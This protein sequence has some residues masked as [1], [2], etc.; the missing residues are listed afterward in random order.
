MY[1]ADG[2][3]LTQT[4]YDE[5]MFALAHPD[6][7][8]DAVRQRTGADTSLAP[9]YRSLFGHGLVDCQIAH[10]DVVVYCE[11]TRK[12]SDWLASYEK[13]VRDARRATL[14]EVAFAVVN[15]LLG[16]AAG[17]AVAYLLF[18]WYGIA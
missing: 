2:I 11:P 14:K 5:L 8:S 10:G 13:S 12:A 4:E 6:G 9:A 17:G 18:I 1:E 7:C 15:T 16:A 3:N